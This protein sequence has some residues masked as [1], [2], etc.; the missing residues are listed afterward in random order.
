M[1]QKLIL[2]DGNNYLNR[3]YHA[4]P[5]LK[6]RDGTPTNAIKG[7]LNI[8]MADLIRLRPTHVG[9]VFDKGGKPNWRCE[10]YPK[11]KQNRQE[12]KAKKDKK[13]KE[14]LRQLAEMHGQCPDLRKLLKRM[15]FRIIRKTGV[16]ADDLM[17]TLAKEYADR[18]WE[19]IMCTNDKDMMQLCGGNIRV[20]TPDRTLM[21]PTEVYHKFG[22]RPS[23][24]VD[25]LCLLG[26]KVD[27]ITGVMGCG[28]ATARSLLEDY[29]SLKAIIKN[30][31]E[32]KP[33][34]MKSVSASREDLKIT[35]KIIR[36]PCDEKHKVTDEDLVFPHPTYDRERVKAFCERLDLTQT[37]KLISQNYKQWTSSPPSKS[38]KR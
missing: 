38:R 6:S 4:T 5:K 25:Y 20:M 31:K 28:P 1:G 33:A 19:V 37:Y 22:V 16:E 23:Q 13:T 8:L 35:P 30:R 15:G 10:V 17:G 21:G 18:G 24:I 34:L 26:D 7:F 14:R 9:V 36:L 29:G 27:N 11:Y 32:L 12:W 3:A 2:I